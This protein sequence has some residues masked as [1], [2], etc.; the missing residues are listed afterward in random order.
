[1]GRVV[2]GR[3]TFKNYSCDSKKHE[4][5]ILRKN[6]YNVKKCAHSLTKKLHPLKKRSI[7]I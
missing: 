6:L 4:H 5:G 3:V 7:C 1:M 2:S